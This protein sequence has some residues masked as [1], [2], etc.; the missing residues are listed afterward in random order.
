M[1]EYKKLYKKKKETNSLNDKLNNQLEESVKEK[2]KLAL[3]NKTL[4]N[5]KASLDESLKDLLKKNKDLI[6]K[7]EDLTK[8]LEK[9]KSLLNRFTLSSNRLD[10]MLKDQQAIFNKAWLGCKTYQKQ[11]SINNIYKKLSYDNLVCFCCDKLGHKSYT[12]NM[13]KCPNSIRIKQVWIIKKSL[14]DKV[15]IPKVT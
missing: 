3:E 6:S 5:K 9:A 13:R 8:D 1:V 7:T 15:E 4:R 2:D 10:M 14:L 11:K 12:C